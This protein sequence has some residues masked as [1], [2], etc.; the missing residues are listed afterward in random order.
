MVLSIKH[1]PQAADS[2]HKIF[3]KNVANSPTNSSFK[4]PMT[5]L[6]QNSAG[7]LATLSQNGVIDYAEPNPARSLTTLSQNSAGSLTTLSQN[8]AGSLTTLSQNSAGSLT[9]LSQNSAG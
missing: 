5:P 9:T 1:L 7:S 4:P 3:S 6:G 2:H 8:S